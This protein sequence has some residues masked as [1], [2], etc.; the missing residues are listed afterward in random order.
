METVASYKAQTT[1]Q[2]D[3]KI[4]LIYGLN[5]TG[6]STLSNFLYDPSNEFFN[7]CAKLPNDGD[8]VFVYNQKFIQDNF[9]DS[10]SL[11]GIFS[12]SKENKQAKEKIQTAEKILADINKELTAK[13]SDKASTMQSFS[14]KKEL[15]LN[16][17]WKIKTTYTGG[18]RVFEY[19]LDN[20]KLKEKL[21]E[22]LIAI[23]KPAIEPQKNIKTLKQEIEALKG[24]DAHP[25]LELP[26]LDFLAHGDESNEVYAKVIVGNNDS[27]VSEL[28]ESLGNSDWVKLG[29]EYIPD[30][31]DNQNQEC[32][33]CQEKTVTQ[34][35]VD[36]I[37]DYFDESY[38]AEIARLETIQDKYKSDY[39]N[40]KSLKT[41]T[42]HPF[43]KEKAAVI[44]QKYQACEKL[45]NDNLNVMAEK[46]K[47][48]S[49]I[50]KLVSSEQAFAAFN[51]EII[52]I[53][54]L[55]EEYNLKLENKKSTLIELKSEF[56]S[57]IRWQYDQTISRFNQDRIETNSKLSDLDKEIEE[58]NKSCTA[59]RKSI[60]EAQQETVNVDDAIE[61]IN[62]GLLELGIDDFKIVKYSD[63]L[64]RIVRSGKPDDAFNTLSE[65]EKM[66]ISFLYFCELCKGRSSADDTSNKRIA[67]IDDPIS[68]MSHIFIFNVGQLIR[69]VFFKSERISQVFV[70][71]HSLYFFYELTDTNKERRKENQKLF[72]LSKS[73][74]G[75]KIQEMKYEEI[76]NDYQAYWSVINDSEQPPALI[77]NCMRNIVEYFFSFVR[78]KDLNNV[79]QM[80][81]LQDIKFQAFNRYIN[82]ESHSL[83]QNIIDM[84]E[85]NYDIFKDG[86]RL[87]FEATGYSD[88][89]KEMSK[90]Y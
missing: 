1:L 58:I 38:Q 87:V 60:V 13:N 4:N 31:I 86:L 6:K 84:K 78:K 57:L 30:H 16:E 27:V 83:G 5:G 11:K 15:A 70:L 85:F 61:A 3:K 64:Y 55:I 25:Q 81:Q 7:K 51:A 39:A 49:S 46:L 28:I 89:F 66:M 59:Q 77:A 10:D 73:G 8:P 33:F 88:H 12:L 23:D 74:T 72:R 35:L 54:N 52:A 36:S 82:R 26:L 29:L 79:F 19:C 48:P 14:S 32:P 42:E 44:T 20:L 80:Q 71:T 63:S 21:F 90:N 18:D 67:V 43:V 53:N 50:Q 47:R 69:S 37:K 9:F 45:L 62:L 17:V 41:Y 65:G 75:S 56:W 24:E 76:Q 2:T 34:N 68:S 40:L 22:H